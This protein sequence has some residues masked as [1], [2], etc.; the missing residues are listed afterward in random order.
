MLGETKE[1]ARDTAVQ[2]DQQGGNF[3]TH[4]KVVPMEIKGQKYWTIVLWQ[5]CSCLTVTSVQ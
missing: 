5:H 3:Y 4:D 1:V 2:L